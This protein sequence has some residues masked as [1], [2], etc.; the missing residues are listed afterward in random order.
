MNVSTDLKSCLYQQVPIVLQKTVKDIYKRSILFGDART[1]TTHLKL[2]IGSNGSGFSSRALL[3]QTLISGTTF[4][5]YV[6]HF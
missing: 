5:A 3:E 1:K 6:F 4:I 2:N